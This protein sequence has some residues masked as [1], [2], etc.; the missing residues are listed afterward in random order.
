MFQ[1]LFLKLL[2]FHFHLSLLLY[3]LSFRKNNNN[4][5][6]ALRTGLLW[7]LI[8][9][10]HRSTQKYSGR[11]LTTSCRAGNVEPKQNREPL[12]PHSVVCEAMFRKV[13]KK[14][15]PVWSS[16]NWSPFVQPALK[17]LHRNQSSSPKTQR[18]QAFY[19]FLTVNNRWLMWPITFHFVEV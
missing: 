5:R 13:R 9:G 2:D 3:Y 11:F 19:N 16:L 4:N 8:T 18:W 15:E 12:L 17:S 1:V 14:R 10:L 7:H 6:I